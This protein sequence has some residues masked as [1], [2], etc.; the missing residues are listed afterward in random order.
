MA[1]LPLSKRLR[2][3]P[4]HLLRLLLRLPRLARVALRQ[5]GLLARLQGLWRF[6]RRAPWAV[7]PLEAPRVLWQ[8]SPLAP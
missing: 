4:R 6:L 7:L 5:A 3:R 1:H 2:Q 8:A